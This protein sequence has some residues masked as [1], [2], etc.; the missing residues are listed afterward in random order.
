MYYLF[1]LLFFRQGCLCNLTSPKC[2]K[3]LLSYAAIG[4]FLSTTARTTIATATI[5]TAATTTTDATATATTM[6]TIS[7]SAEVRILK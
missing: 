2:S 7:S 6:M 4:S 3:A 5:T 1:I